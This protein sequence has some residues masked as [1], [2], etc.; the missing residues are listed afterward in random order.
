MTDS[1]LNAGPRTRSDAGRTLRATPETKHI[2][3]TLDPVAIEARA[4]SALP[5]GADEVVSLPGAR[6]LRVVADAGA[7]VAA[8]A[9]DSPAQSAAE[10]S[11]QERPARSEFVTHPLSRRVIPYWR[12]RR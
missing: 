5:P 2:N 9:P 7:R 6:R 10:P 11:A 4:L 8:E 12:R 1:N 3:D